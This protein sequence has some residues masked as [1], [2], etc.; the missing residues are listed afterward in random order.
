MN[1]WYQVRPYLSNTLRFLRI[2]YLETRSDYEGTRPGLLW[3]HLSTVIFT[4]M[5]AI[6]FRHSDTMPQSYFFLYVL[7]GYVIWLFITDTI[8]GSIDIIQ[9][10]LEFA[11]HNNLSLPGLFLK[12]LIDRL[13]EYFI[14]LAVLLIALI[15]L[16]PTKIGFNLLLFF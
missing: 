6:A 14:N 1:L 3:L 4:L 13:F 15:L 5:L 8:T 2:S 10:R 7:S 9:K 11:V 16:S 12:L